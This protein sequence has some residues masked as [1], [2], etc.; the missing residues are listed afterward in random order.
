VV[1]CIGFSGHRD[2]PIDIGALHEW[3]LALW[4]KH[5]GATW[6]HGGADGFDSA[7]HAFILL[8]DIPRKV[9]RPDYAKYPPKV[10]PLRRNVQIV[11]LSDAMVVFWDGREHGGTYQTRRYAESKKKAILNLY[12]SILRPQVQV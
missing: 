10:A 1:H 8:H 5:P 7:V 2:L 12:P 3:L 4:R 11:D 6:V 9:I